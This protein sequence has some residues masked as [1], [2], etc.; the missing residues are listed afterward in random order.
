MESFDVPTALQYLN[1]P[2]SL[3]GFTIFL[4]LCFYKLIVKLGIIP[5]LSRGHGNLLLHKII[6]FTFVL[7]MFVAVA[8]YGL[9]FVKVTGEPVNKDQAL[10][11]S[12]KELEFGLNNKIDFGNEYFREKIAMEQ[13]FERKIKMKSV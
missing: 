1:N 11:L 5:Q 3:T 2:F 10:E 4:L 7:A 8:G 6:N 13:S 9:E 12:K